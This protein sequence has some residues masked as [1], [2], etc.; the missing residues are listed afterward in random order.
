[1]WCMALAF[2]DTNM[3][4]STLTPKMPLKVWQV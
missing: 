4:S 1:L 3:T 2:N